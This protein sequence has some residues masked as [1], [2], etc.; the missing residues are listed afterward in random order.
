MIHKNTRQIL[1][2][3][4]FGLGA[5]INKIFE[6]LLSLLNIGIKTYTLFRFENSSKKEIT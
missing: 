6:F 2:F 4:I 1:P 5:F 3:S